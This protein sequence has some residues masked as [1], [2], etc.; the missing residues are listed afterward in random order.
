MYVWTGM[1]VGTPMSLILRERLFWWSCSRQEGNSKH[2]G[3]FL[4]AVK[5]VSGGGNGIHAVAARADCT[6]PHVR[7]H[8]T[9]RWNSVTLE[10][11]TPWKLAGATNQGFLLPTG[12]DHSTFTRNILG[13]LV[14]GGATDLGF[15]WKE[16]SFWV[17]PWKSEACFVFVYFSLSLNPLILKHSF[18]GSRNSRS[19]LSVIFSGILETTEK[20]KKKKN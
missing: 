19:T 16:F 5:Q 6:Q 8:H 15:Y 18:M 1:Q 12:K 7:W 20:R 17:S 3:W 13:M 14:G 4:V 2:V 9:D 11:F 10:T